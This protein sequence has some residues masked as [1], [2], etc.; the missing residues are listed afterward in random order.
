VRIQDGSDATGPHLLLHNT[1]SS[2]D[3]AVSFVSGNVDPSGDFVGLFNANPNGHY[4]I[5]VES[6]DFNLN[7]PFLPGLG[8]PASLLPGQTVVIKTPAGSINLGTDASI[9]ATGA[10]DVLL[11]ALNGI[12]LAGMSVPTDPQLSG[13]IVSLASSDVSIAGKIVAT[14]AVDIRPLTPTTPIELGTSG[15][16]GGVLALDNA[17]L[18]FLFAPNL[19]IGLSTAPITITGAIGP[20]NA[21]PNLFASTVSGSGVITNPDGVS[22]TTWTGGIELASSIHDVGFLFADTTRAPGA[23]INFRNAGT[24]LLDPVTGILTD[25]GNVTIETTGPGADIQ[26]GRIAT[27]PGNPVASGIVTLTS[28][29]SIVDSGPG[30]FAASANLTAANSIGTLADPLET[31][32]PVINLASTCTSGCPAV[33]IGIINNGDLALNSL[34]VGWGTSTAAVY[35]STQFGALSGTLNV[36]AAVNVQGALSLLGDTGVA[37]ANSV[38]A[39]GP[40]VVQSGSLLDIGAVSVSGASV[41]LSGAT[42]ALNGSNINAATSA[43]LSGGT[44]N[45]NGSSIY[46]TDVTLSGGTLN[47]TGSYVYGNNTVGLHGGTINVVG[48]SVGAGS[49]LNVGSH[50]PGSF[51]PTSIV[52]TLTIDGG[53]GYAGSE[54]NMT[55]GTLIT[56]LNG[57]RIS[58]GSPETINILFP[59]LA[60]GGFMVDSVAD[61]Y[62]GGA[63]GF[64]LPTGQVVSLPTAGF[65]VTYGGAVAVDPCSLAPEVCFPPQNGEVTTFT[66]PEEE[67]DKDKKPTTT[68]STQEAKEGEKD[69]KGLPVCK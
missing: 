6:G 36:P 31:Q 21:Y 60:S 8:A 42:V 19:A 1:G 64:Y 28:T 12:A 63:S 17:E 25:G 37:L 27:G 3:I 66:T 48:S 40:L 55:I 4:A 38:A 39:A 56:L 50:V 43:S 15:T 11:E 53:E 22:I 29:G 30:I 18:Q 57:G 5:Q 49:V 41:S 34:S 45:A 52:G 26:V 7:I 33:E 32:V 59:L 2:G 9:L 44:V 61:V 51:V 24:L 62:G 67:E 13:D 16:Q 20:F 35:S 23:S 47:L 46:G 69:K 54:V 65:N 58:V 68:A 14:G 10:G